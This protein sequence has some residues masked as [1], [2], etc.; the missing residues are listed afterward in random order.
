MSKGQIFGLTVIVTEIQERSD[1]EL[2][3]RSW[4]ELVL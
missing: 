3:I 1:L 2:A 4:V